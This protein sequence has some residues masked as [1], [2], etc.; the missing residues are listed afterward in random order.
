[1]TKADF[2]GGTYKDAQIIPCNQYSYT[3]QV[4]P[5]ANSDFTANAAVTINGTVL[6]VNI[7]T[8]F[9]STTSKGYFPDHTELQ[10][11]TK[12][13]F[14]NFIVK[15]AVYGDS[16]YVQINTVPGSAAGTFISEDAG[17]PREFTITICC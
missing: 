6:P 15:R 12:G 3:L 13:G 11:S 10:W 16:N 17:A 8:V 1:M 9:G 7:G 2:D 5:P 4:V 14:D